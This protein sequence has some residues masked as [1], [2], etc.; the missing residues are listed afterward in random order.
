MCTHIHGFPVTTIELHCTLGGPSI[1]AA[2]ELSV[3]ELNTGTTASQR[4]TLEGQLWSRCERKT[5]WGVQG[6]V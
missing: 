4:Q 1:K 3:T 6:F 2:R 5:V